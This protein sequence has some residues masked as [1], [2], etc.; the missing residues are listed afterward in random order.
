MSLRTLWTLTKYL[1]AIAAMLL[2]AALVL[3]AATILL[4][5]I[6]PFLRQL[7]RA[8]RALSGALTLLKASA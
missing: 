8:H 3:H 5:E 2:A 7:Q 6:D 4:E 1:R